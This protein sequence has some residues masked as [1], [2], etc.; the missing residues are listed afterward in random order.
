M[1]ICFAAGFGSRWPLRRL[2]PIEGRQQT[3]Y[4]NFGAR[5]QDAAGSGHEKGRRRL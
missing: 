2:F 5:A 3:H 4:R 1:I